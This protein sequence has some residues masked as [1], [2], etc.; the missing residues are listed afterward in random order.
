MLRINRKWK[1]SYFPVV[2]PF[3]PSATKVKS[4]FLE[5][6][7]DHMWFSF[8]GKNSQPSS[9]EIFL[10]AAAM[11]RK[12]TKLHQESRTCFLKTYR[13]RYTLRIRRPGCASRRQ[14]HRQLR[15][16][17]QRSS[18]C[19]PFLSSWWRDKFQSWRLR[20][21]RL[22]VRSTTWIARWLEG[23]LSDGWTWRRQS[24]LKEIVFRIC[25]EGF[26]RIF[27]PQPIAAANAILL[28]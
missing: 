28:V 24:H 14:Q 9:R 12:H 26:E 21:C 6:G 7:P 4:Y 22:L 10:V 27:L 16:H 18:T 5:S 11:A 17:R 13:M 8:L 3:S 20:P 25:F 23:I 15:K 19:R 2:Q 1:T